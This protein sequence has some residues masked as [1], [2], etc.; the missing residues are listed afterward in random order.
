MRHYIIDGYNALFKIKSS[1]KKPYQ[2]REGFIQYI[3]VSKP[4][5]SIK[6]R[7]T[8]VFD[9]TTGVVSNQKYSYAPI[10]VIFAKNESAD[11]LIIKIAKTEN[12]SGEIIVVTDD[13]EVREKTQLLGCSTLSVLQFFKDLTKKKE[14]EEKEKPEP[15]SKEGENIT[16]E[17]KQE[18]GIEYKKGLPIEPPENVTH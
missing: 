6:N 9:G 4:F 5:G 17:M 7:V 16:D 13:R 15:D 14:T 1:L 8:I 11:D 2:T 3:S 18:R 10:N 12:K